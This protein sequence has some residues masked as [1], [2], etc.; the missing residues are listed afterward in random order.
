MISHHLSID[1]SLLSS[2]KKSQPDWPKNGSVMAKKRMSIY[3][4][5]GILRGILA[6]NLVNYQ[7]FSIKSSLLDNY[8]HFTYS[9]RVSA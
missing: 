1:D 9:V 5:I 2:E 6:H 8:H 4:M 3:G 7:Y